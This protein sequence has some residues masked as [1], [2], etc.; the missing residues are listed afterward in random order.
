MQNYL[1][2]M[3]EYVENHETSLIVAFVAGKP[4]TFYLLFYHKGVM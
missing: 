4:F 1:E 3:R 2:V